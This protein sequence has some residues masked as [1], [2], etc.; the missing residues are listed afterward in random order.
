VF[1]TEQSSLFRFLRPRKDIRM[2]SRLVF[3][4]VASLSFGLMFVALTQ[5]SQAETITVI[6]SA[7][8]NGIDGENTNARGGVICA[9]SGTQQF[10]FNVVRKSPTV[11]VHGPIGV[12]CLRAEP[13]NVIKRRFEAAG[14]EFIGGPGARSRHRPQKNR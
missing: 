10:I 7:G 13:P 1:D 14:A 11:F 9:P 3:A 12:R 2:D 6:G 8:V 4:T 5:P